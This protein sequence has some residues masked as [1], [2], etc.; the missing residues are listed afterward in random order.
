[1]AE[2]VNVQEIKDK[3]YEKLKGTGWEKLRTFML[4]GDMDEILIK[5]IEDVEVGKRFTPPL[6][7]V[8]KALEETHLDN[9]RVVIIGQDP[10]PQLNVAD[11][12]A[13]SCSNN[14][15]VEK[16]LGFMFKSIKATVDENYVGDP[17]LRC[18][19]SQGVLLLNSALTTTIGKPGTH[20]L[21]WQ[22][23]IMYLLDVLTRT[24]KDIVYV[25]LGKKAQELVDL[26]PDS[27]HKIMVS[28]PA[29]AAYN[30]TVWECNDMWNEINNYLDERGQQRIS[31]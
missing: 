8:F 11:G 7:N 31:W 1:M 9:V 30:G 23:F 29:S 22:P 2:K 3:L 10:Y 6:K 17:D 24:K 20:Y 16:S 14:K 4:S 18:W 21:L 25:F 28:H 27:N 12:I 26:I 19:T 5:L 13:F 15:K